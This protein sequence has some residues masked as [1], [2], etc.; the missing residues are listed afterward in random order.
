[1]CKYVLESCK[2]LE[3]ERRSVCWSSNPESSC[4]VEQCLNLNLQSGGCLTLLTY[5]LRTVCSQRIDKAKLTVDSTKTGKRIELETTTTTPIQKERGSSIATSS[6]S[7]LSQLFPFSS[8][9]PIPFPLL[10]L[11]F[12]ILSPFSEPSISSSKNRI[13]PWNFQSGTRPNTS[14]FYL[15]FSLCYQPQLKVG[16]DYQ[17]KKL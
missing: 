4:R 1:M 6:S 13:L 5:S 3:V 2:R 16:M 12:L 17:I 14:L 9:S 7:P 11:S 10:L 8:P 15:P